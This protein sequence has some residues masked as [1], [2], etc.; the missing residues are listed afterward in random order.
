MHRLCVEGVGFSTKFKVRKT[1]TKTEK[2]KETEL[3]DCEQMKFFYN[4]M[5]S[6][7]GLVL[8][9][10]AV[11]LGILKHAVSF[12]IEIIK[13]LLNFNEVY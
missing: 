7:N 10:R 9:N 2:R 6:S 12:N 4:E 11:G 8:A 3:C 13:L 5:N 1:K